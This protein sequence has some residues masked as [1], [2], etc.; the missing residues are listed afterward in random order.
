MAGKKTLFTSAPRIKLLIDSKTIAYAV[1]FNVSVNI[2][3]QPVNVMGQFGPITIEP[4]M[5]NVVTG[6]MQILKLNSTGT[7]KN[8]KDKVDGAT[9]NLSNSGFNTAKVSPSDAQTAVYKNS[10]VIESLENVDAVADHLNPA[11][12]LASKTFDL[13][14]YLRINDGT[15][16]AKDSTT[17]GVGGNER[18]WL[19]I[20]DVRLGSKN[21][22]IT[23]G[24]L[25]N[26][27]VSFQGLLLSPTDAA[28]LEV[29]SQDMQANKP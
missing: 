27:P 15:N 6:T 5:Y 24:Q 4:T 17:V 2:G 20:I 19:K 23:M 11:S 8:I 25:V 22:N 29:F 9:P 28:G 21:T 3:L 18:L 13:D 10:S 16:S 14:I 12:V 7:M 1:G 26:E